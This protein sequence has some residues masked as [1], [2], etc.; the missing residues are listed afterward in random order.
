MRLLAAAITLALLLLAGCASGDA[1]APDP[2]P[3]ADGP[4]AGQGVSVQTMFDTAPDA[5]AI[6][7]Q[8][9]LVPA[10]A[11]VSVQA[12]TGGGNTM[13]RLA[14]QGLLPDRTYGAHAHTKPCGPM[15]DAAGPHFQHEPDPNQPSTDPAFA[16]PQNEVWLDLTTDASGAAMVES[17]VAFEFTEQRPGSVV[18]HESGTSSEPGKAGTAGPRI[19]CVTVGF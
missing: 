2:T 9:A 14:V 10:G 3:A 16:N 19:A 13:V 17:N 12:R 15:G 6:T 4:E 1:A 5:R 18:I 8:P 11:E 7:Y